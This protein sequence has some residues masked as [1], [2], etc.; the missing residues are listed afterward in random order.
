MVRRGKRLVKS[1]MPPAGSFYIA[2][3][4]LSRPFGRNFRGKDASVFAFSD[5]ATVVPVTCWLD[6]V[7]SAHSSTLESSRGAKGRRQPTRDSQAP[8]RPRLRRVRP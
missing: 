7:M 6:Y 4:R 5:P 8:S 1:V 3:C 2:S